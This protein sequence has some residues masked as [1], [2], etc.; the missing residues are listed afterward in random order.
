MSRIPWVRI[1]Y[2]Y[3]MT[4]IGLIVF[5]IGSVTI[6][7]TGLKAFV[8]T[9]ADMNYNG[10]P[11]ELYLAKSVNQ[12]EALK[13]CDQ[14]TEA[15]KES[16]TMWLADYKN[17]QENNKNQNPAT[18]NRQREAA[19]AIAMILVGFPVYFIHWRII[20]KEKSSEEIV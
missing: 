19:T 15:D 7:N 5:I 20:Q 4:A 6:V 13:T 18:S 11:S 14:F 12:I 8:F 1:V 10:G 17:W 16:M 2:L 3:L 9:K